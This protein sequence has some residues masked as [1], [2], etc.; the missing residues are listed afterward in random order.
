MEGI[1][2]SREWATV[3]AKASGSRIEG[4][5]TNNQGRFVTHINADCDIEGR[6]AEY[7]ISPLVDQ[8][9]TFKMKTVKDER[10]EY[11]GEDTNDAFPGK[12]GGG[13][14]W[15][16]FGQPAVPE[17][18]WYPKIINPGLSVQKGN[19][20]AVCPSGDACTGAELARI[21]QAFSGNWETNEGDIVAT[22]SG[23][24]MQ[25]SLSIGGQ[26]GKITGTVQPDGSLKG[27]WN[28]SKDSHGEFIFWID[29]TGKHFTGNATD[30]EMPT[31]WNEGWSGDKVGG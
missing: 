6:W 8:S 12:V 11:L 3:Y 24:T 26:T 28:V 16:K 20:H 31:V 23:T 18:D 15:R 25:G 22:T 4:T 1:W 13:W 14:G 30:D 9:G 7:Q 29:P 17:P 10:G 21:A 2:D 5:Y 19:Q 27:R